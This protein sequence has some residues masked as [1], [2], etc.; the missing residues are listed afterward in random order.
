MSFIKYNSLMHS[1][2]SL[3]NYRCV[4]GTLLKVEGMCLFVSY[5]AL[6]ISSVLVATVHR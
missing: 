4:V 6:P 3:K 5:V 1:K 2:S